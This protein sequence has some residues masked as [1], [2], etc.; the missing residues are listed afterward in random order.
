V[1]A[2]SNPLLS[3]SQLPFDA[4]AF[5]LIRDEDFEP[6]V[7]QGIRARREEV[8]AIAAQTEPPTF[9]NTI[10]A[11]E[12][13]GRLLSNVRMTFGNLTSANTNP[14]LQRVQESLA[15]KLSAADDEILLN[16]ALFERIEAVYNARA[17][18]DLDS[19]ALRLVEYT[20]Q[21]FV[22]SGARLSADDKA[23]LK[24]LNE[25]DATLQ[26]QFRNRLLA[27]AKDG[28]LI[29]R[30]RSALAGLTDDELEAAAEA[31]RARG[32]AGQWAIPLHNTTQQPAL[33]SLENRDTRRALFQA[34]WLR[35]ERGDA[36]D[37]RAIIV[38]LARIRA[39]T[40]SLLGFQDYA[41]WALQD[42]MAATP[43]AVNAFL[44]QLVPPATARARVEADDLQAQID[45]QGGGFTLEAWDWPFYAEQ[46]RK[47][48]Y[49]LDETELKP[50]FELTRVLT[51]G[52]FF[53]AHALYGL[54]FIE[55]RDL[56]V[57]H[58]DVQVYEIR[59]AEGA[60][61]GLFYVDLF[62]RDNKA[63]GAWMDNYRGQSTLL[64]E[65][66]I[67]C[68]VA[69]F[70]K[71]AP[72]H[73]ALVSFDDVITLFH[74]FGHALHGLL[75]NG[76][77]PSLSGTAVA[78]DFVELPSQFNEY[79][80]LEP[81]V[82]ANY[83]VH[84]RTGATMPAELVE[85]IRRARDFN[86]GYDMT[87]L[88]A[89]AHLDL[90]WHTLAPETAIQRVEEFER[91]ALERTGLALPQVPTRY[92]SSYFLHIWANGYAAGY[93][94]YLWSRMLADDAFAWFEAHGGM[95]R[96]NGE[97]FRKTILSRGNGADY[98]QMYRD[99]TGRDPDIAPMLAYRGLAGQ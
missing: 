30:D 66:P 80:A 8:E 47:A 53:A 86:A 83:A 42:Q 50:Y 64:D 85:K 40:A 98:G 3:P 26:V 65:R 41:A 20:H 37:T 94:A 78:R 6:A 51:D 74:E 55:R 29:V 75:A 87:E 91:A 44:D 77:Y 76:R 13:S 56:P 18:H 1:H 70:P 46:L 19:E 7:E 71:P 9:E 31:A 45:R 10:V 81:A 28:A 90:Q 57:Y 4:P 14:V 22:L 62:A 43:A 68:N 25:E 69:N 93:Y 17:G 58:D 21:R 16:G 34:S 32:A 88:L 63:G 24:A 82:L 48:A 23:R 99:L 92:R 96:E 72:G 73:P 36:N 95:T 59:D 27:A 2:R 54:T 97:H 61:L 12:R 52:V 11:L 39:E 49:D 33:V 79:W 5:D 38:R 89:A 60:A 84:C 35:T 67:I 15:P